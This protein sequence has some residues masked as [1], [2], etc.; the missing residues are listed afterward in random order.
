MIL[1]LWS[2]CTL[3]QWPDVW[4]EGIPG[5]VLGVPGWLGAE[6]LVLLPKG[7]SLLAK[8]LMDNDITAVI[9]EAGSDEI[10]VVFEDDS[11]KYL[12]SPSLPE[13]TPTGIANID[14]HPASRLLTAQAVEQLIATLVTEIRPTPALSLPSTEVDTSSLAVPDREF[15][16]WLSKIESTSTEQYPDPTPTLAAYTS[17]SPDEHTGRYRLAMRGSHD[18]E[19]TFEIEPSSAQ[20]VS[21]SVETVGASNGSGKSSTHEAG[22][23]STEMSTATA[24]S[25]GPEPTA[26]NS[27]TALLNVQ[28]GTKRSV[29]EDN[30]TDNS[31]SETAATKRRQDEHLPSGGAVTG[32]DSGNDCFPDTGEVVKIAIDDMK[33]ED[34]GR[35]SDTGE[36]VKIAID[37]MKLEDLLGGVFGVGYEVDV[38]FV[39]KTEAGK[40]GYTFEFDC[41]NPVYTIPH[42]NRDPFIK[43]GY[44]FED[45]SNSRRHL[46]P[47]AKKWLASFKE[48]CLKPLGTPF[49]WIILN[50]TPSL[51]QNC[52]NTGYLQKDGHYIADPEELCPCNCRRCKQLESD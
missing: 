10:R 3:A 46:S 31:C 13:P 50:I 11:E 52:A 47:W 32:L 5:S 39:S 7:N 2:S 14:A 35:Y 30:D 18:L 19:V 9:R 33:L 15:D 41:E 38:E 44:T 26:G 24:D 21:F 23:S 45:L 25:S 36:V 28:A 43:L 20:A 12:S 4:A 37:D 42:W 51:C 8:R 1:L 49:S 6:H 48:R 29:C 17:E 34:S 27:G 16:T 22:E 40:R